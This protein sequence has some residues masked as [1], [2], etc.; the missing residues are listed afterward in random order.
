MKNI[1]NS[2]VIVII[3]TIFTNFLIVQKQIKKNKGAKKNFIIEHVLLYYRDYCF[4][5]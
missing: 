2:I 5:R 3:I 1:E 4:S